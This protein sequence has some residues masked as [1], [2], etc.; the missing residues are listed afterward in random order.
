MLRLGMDSRRGAPL[1]RNAMRLKKSWKL[2]KL[3][4]WS[5]HMPDASGRRFRCS[6]NLSVRRYSIE[7]RS[8]G[9]II[10]AVNPDGMAAQ[11]GLEP[12]DMI[13]D[14]NRSPVSRPSQVHQAL[15]D[16]KSQN[17]H[18]VLLKVKTRK[19]TVFVAIPLALG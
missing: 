18:D 8:A 1:S 15:A 19:R 16:A 13:L 14:V 11:H 10:T 17:K 7:C 9:V 5:I 4:A 12:G 6:A 2:R 3:V